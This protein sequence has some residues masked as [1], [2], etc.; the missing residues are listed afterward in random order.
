[1]QD[2]LGHRN[3]VYRLTPAINAPDSTFL[4]GATRVVEVGAEYSLYVHD[5]HFL[6]AL[7]V[8]ELLMKW[9]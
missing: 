3:L 9:V 8:Y 2:V 1:M 7:S 6:C 4:F 5:L